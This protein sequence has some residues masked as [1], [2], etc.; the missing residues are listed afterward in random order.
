[1]PAPKKR[2][3]PTRKPIPT[4]RSKKCNRC[5]QR[6]KIA[7]FSTHWL[8]PDGHK[9][10]CRTCH[11]KS[12]SRGRKKAKANGLSKPRKLKLATVKPPSPEMLMSE[13]ARQG[14][15]RVEIDPETQTAIAWRQET[16][17]LGGRK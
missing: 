17:E 11:G 5:K 2:K 12:T 15:R 3:R 10:I 14:F 4:P 8:A 7:E 13:L 16:Y 6:K 9:G 1:M